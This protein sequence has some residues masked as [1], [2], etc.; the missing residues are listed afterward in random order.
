[1]IAHVP[2]VCPY[3]KKKFNVSES[4]IDGLLSTMKMNRVLE[5]AHQMHEKHGPYYDRWLAAMEAMG[6]RMRCSDCLSH[7]VGHYSYPDHY[8]FYKLK[9]V[10]P[11]WF[12]CKHISYYQG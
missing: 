10:H 9:V 8:C 4:F 3:C 2:L 6:E 5:V 7:H 1:M 12:A 11:A